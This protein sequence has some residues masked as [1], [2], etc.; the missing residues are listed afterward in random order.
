[1]KKKEFRFLNRMHIMADASDEFGTWKFLS[2]SFGE[3]D[4][5]KRQA[6]NYRKF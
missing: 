5:S 1:M 4:L 3:D 2:S 6:L